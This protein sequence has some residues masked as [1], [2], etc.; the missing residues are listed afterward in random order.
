M[1]ATFQEV[2]EALEALYEA[3]PNHVTYNKTFLA[4]HGNGPYPAISRTDLQAEVRSVIGVIEEGATDDEVGSDGLAAIKTKLELMQSSLVPQLAQQPQMAVSAFLD[5]IAQIRNSI[6]LLLPAPDATAISSALRG[7][8]RRVKN[9][10][11][12]LVDLEPRTTTLDAMLSRI[13]AAHDTADQLPADLDYLAEKRSTVEQMAT[14]AEADRI[15]IAAAIEFLEQHKVRIE[16]FADQAE[17]TLKSCEEAYRASTSVGLAAAF[18][19]RAGKLNKSVWWW[20]AWLVAALTAAV[21]LGLS[22]MSRLAL[23]IESPSI[24]TSVVVLNFLTSILSVGAPI[25]LAWLATK[26]IGQ[27]FRL[28]EDYAFKASISRAY[29][30]YRQEAARIDEDLEVQLLSSAL[31]RLDELPLRLVETHSH[32]SPWH[33]LLSSEQVQ[34]ALKTIPNFAEEI[35]SLANSK[36]GR[37]QS[38]TETQ[39]SQ[40]ALTENNEN[41]AKG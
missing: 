39:T 36:L 27:R 37:R 17:K 21:F 20:T 30:G 24:S 14:E 18:S 28:S 33:E 10:E 2:I 15:K 7:Q 34:K 6:H 4:Q 32:G 26:Q 12:Q 35:K 41:E 5:S 11:S 22:Q 9:L 23:L 16:N 38:K 1:S 19:E 25:W 31:T 29:E 3:I 13:E 40:S 8:R